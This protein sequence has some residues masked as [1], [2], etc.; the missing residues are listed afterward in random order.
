VEPV[1]SCRASVAVLP[2]FMLVLSMLNTF[3]LK[4]ET[5]DTA[6]TFVI[7]C[8]TTWCHILNAAIFEDCV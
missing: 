4:M 7:I 6:E 1:G 8:Q 2:I 3:T 5:A